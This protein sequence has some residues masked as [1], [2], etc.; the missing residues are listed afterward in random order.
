M[1]RTLFFS[2]CQKHTVSFFHTLHQVSHFVSNAVP[3]EYGI[4]SIL[5]FFLRYI[6]R[7]EEVIRSGANFFRKNSSGRLNKSHFYLW[8]NI[9]GH[10][11]SFIE[12]VTSPMMEG[13]RNADNSLPRLP[14]PHVLSLE[15]GA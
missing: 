13:E 7:V 5:E 11:F 9:F 6:S 1:A 12:S 3:H 8:W 4:K 2:L 10:N 15:A 14:I